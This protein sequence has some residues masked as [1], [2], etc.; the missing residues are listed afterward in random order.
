MVYNHTMWIWVCKTL[1]DQMAAPDGRCVLLLFFFPLSAQLSQIVVLPENEI[2]NCL[3]LAH[4]FFVKSSVFASFIP[5][6]FHHP[7]FDLCSILRTIKTWKW[8][9]PGTRL[10]T[11]RQGGRS[12]CQPPITCILSSSLVRT[13]WLSPRRQL[14]IIWS[15]CWQKRKFRGY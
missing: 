12:N 15:N 13:D 8:E 3:Y 7:V 5:R 14:K 6:P 10:V 2:M 11:R 4:I 9:G 1:A